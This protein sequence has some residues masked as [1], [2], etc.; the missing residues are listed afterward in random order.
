ML[1]HQSPGQWKLIAGVWPL[2][3]PAALA[4]GLG[5]AGLAVPVYAASQPCA[6]PRYPALAGPW[7][8][9]C[10]ADG[11]V[12]HVVSVHSGQQFPLPIS[13][14][15][16]AL[17]DGTIYIPGLRG[18]LIALQEGGPV[19][20]DGTAVIH[21]PTV[22]PAAIRGQRVAVLG[23]DTVQTALVSEASRRLY[24]A[25]PVG[26]YPPALTETGVA[27]VDT[28]GQPTNTEIWWMSLSN[29]Q[30]QQ[31]A[32]EGRHVVGSDTHLVWV[33]DTH[34]IKH[35]IADGHQTTVNVQT[36]FL[37]APTIWQDVVCWEHWG[38][39]GDV[40]ISCDDGLNV[41]RPGH[42]HH[43]SRWGRWLL[44]QE[45]GQSWLMTAMEP[46]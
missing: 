13:A 25:S 28:G 6:D 1:W 42:Q 7:V 34:L 14:R 41:H 20:V 22:S 4:S 33:T 2:L 19:R 5:H 23:E 36:G 38:E 29:D 10:G 35:D 37:S 18:G 8:V 24:P 3:V 30:P 40:D 21:T 27:W 45:A 26:W 46:S 15:S 9:A 16:P 44:F 17:G 12:D 39:L 11:L 32:A 43:P 31:L